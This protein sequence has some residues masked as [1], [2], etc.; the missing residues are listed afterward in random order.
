MR[1][2]VRLVLAL[3][4][5]HVLSLSG[6]LAGIPAVRAADTGGWAAVNTGLTGTSVLCLAINPRSPSTLYAGTDTG[7]VFRSTDS[8]ATWKAV[9]TGLTTTYVSALAIISNPANLATLYAG[10]DMGVFL[11]TDSGATW[12]AG[13]P[14][15]GVVVCLAI[16]PLS[17]STLYAGSNIGVFRS[18]DSGATWTEVNTGIANPETSSLAINP[19]DPS[20]LYAGTDSGVFLST[21]SGATWTAAG[22]T[23]GVVVCLA[24][25]PLNPSTVYASTDSGVSQYVGV[26][27]YVLTAVASPASGGS[28]GR[29]PDAVSYAPG[30]VVTLT[31]TPA[32]GYVLIGWSG[33]FSGPPTNPPTITMDAD[34]TV[35]ASFAA[36]GKSVI[37]LKIGSRTMYVDGKPIILDAAPIILHSRTLLPIRAVVEA[38]GGTIAWEAS[39][40]KVTIV[41]KGKTLQLWIDRNV[42]TLNGKSVNIDSDPKVVPIIMNS[43]TLLPLRFVAEALAMDIQWNATTQAITI[44]YTP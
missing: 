4:L 43:R 17:P 26:S 7:G 15:D 8:G 42:A 27:S 9:N 39:T 12:T 35:T 30:T 25:N 34:K 32:A 16:N 3:V 40:R 18:T 29:S 5:C 13:G 23:D 14:I 22:S 38:T 24:I 37:L 41:R 21:D 28:I 11:S 6:V 36:K 2:F 19:L 20:T 1:Q 10:T 33:D 31:A 44:T